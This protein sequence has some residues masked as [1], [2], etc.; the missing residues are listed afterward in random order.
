MAEKILI[1]RWTTKTLDFYGTALAVKL[2]AL[3]KKEAP[4]FMRHMVELA[5]LAQ[6]ADETGK[7]AVDMMERWGGAYVEGVFERCVKPAE[8]FDLDGTTIET[9][10]QLYAEG[11]FPFAMSVLLALQ[12]LAAVGPDQGNASGSLSAPV[13]AAVPSGSSTEAA[14]STDGSLGA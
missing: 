12:A 2:R 7:S 11:S 3:S 5:E 6:G 4:E 1:S 13:P 14:P 10:A 8:P 9:G